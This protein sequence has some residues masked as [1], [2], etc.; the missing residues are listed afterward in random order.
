M[1]RTILF[2]L[3]IP[4]LLHCSAEQKNIKEE[5]ILRQ[6]VV[7]IFSKAI[8]L[9][10]KFKAGVKKD[11]LKIQQKRRRETEQYDETILPL[12]LKNSIKLLSSGNDKE[13]AI[14]FFNL[15]ISY[16]NSADEEL[17]YTLAEIYSKNPDL[18]IKVFNNFNYTQRLYLYK[19][20]I[21]GWENINYYIKIPQ[22][23][24]RNLI[25]KL[26]ELRKKLVEKAN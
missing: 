16:E 14:C 8:K 1:I 15:L 22:K 26:E 24:K 6:Q 11:P 10:E 3:F 17:S 2:L 12:A 21:W 9:N 13:L 4:L 25:K 20:L 19:E 5:N 23:R 7:E 18:I